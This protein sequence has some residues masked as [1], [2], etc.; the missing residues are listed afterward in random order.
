MGAQPR[1]LLVAIGAPPTTDE[2]V[3]ERLYAGIAEACGTFGVDVIG[4]DTARASEFIV[5]ITAFGVAENEPMRRSGAVAGDV[6]AVSG[7]LG[8]AAAGVELL[9]IHRQDESPSC[10]AAHRR[11][12]VRVDLASGL[13]SSGVH[14][15]MDISDGLGSD[16]QRIAEASRVGVEID[17]AAVPVADEVREL[18]ERHGWDALELALCGGEDY[19]LLVAGPSDAVTAAGFIEVGRIVADGAWLVTAGSREPLGEGYD[20]FRSV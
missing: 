5:E 16:A 13:A 19:E 11:P 17:A 10:V 18:A 14:A 12:A 2:D 20:N 3:V 7:P 9:R 15:A 4:G 1:W 6:L 8:K